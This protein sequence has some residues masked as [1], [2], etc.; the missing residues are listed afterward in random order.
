MIKFDLICDKQHSFEAW[1]SGNEDFEKQRDAKLVECPHCGSS[2]VEK[3][4]MAPSVSTAR[5]KE[6]SMQLAM[7]NTQK[8]A[9]DQLRQA[10]KTIRENSEDVGERFPE[11]AR[12]IHYGESEERGI[13]G[14]AKPDEVKSLLDEGVGVAPLPDLPEEKN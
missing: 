1:F 6:A 8:A 7:N 4:L 9:I 5:S 14:Q 10:V 13:I 11:E 12:K 2:S 3:A